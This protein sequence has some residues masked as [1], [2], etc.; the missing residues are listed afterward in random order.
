MCAEDPNSGPC[1]C[2]AS[3]FPTEPSPQPL[4]PAVSVVV[5]YMEMEK[6]KLGKPGTLLRVTQVIGVTHKIQ[7]YHRTASFLLKH[8]V[9]LCLPI[10]PQTHKAHVPQ[11][12]QLGFERYEQ[13]PGVQSFGSV[14]IFCMCKAPHVIGILSGVSNL[15]PEGCLCPW[16]S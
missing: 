2:S 12:P 3:S 4:P 14:C 15:R 1:A 8:C 13:Y 6:V 5:L 10:S 16:D 9:S 11:T 7:T